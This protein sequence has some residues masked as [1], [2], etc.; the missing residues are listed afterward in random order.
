[1]RSPTIRLVSRLVFPSYSNRP[2]LTTGFSRTARGKSHSGE[3]PTTSSP[4]PRA[5]QISV[6]EGSSETIRIGFARSD[7]RQTAKSVFQVGSA[8]A[9]RRLAQIAPGASLGGRGREDPNAAPAG[10]A[11]SQHQQGEVRDDEED[12]SR[13]TPKRGAH[14]SRAHLRRREETQRQVRRFNPLVHGRHE[15]GPRGSRRD[16]AYS[17]REARCVPGQAL[18]REQK[19]GKGRVANRR[20]SRCFGVGIASPTTSRRR[21]RSA[22]C[23]R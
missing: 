13:G 18:N 21:V 11:R 22:S 7:S 9:P 3:T 1:M 6:A 10:K 2:W 19:R 16:S 5:K 15:A 8:E 20:C 4:R 12:D 14:A 17:R 23:R